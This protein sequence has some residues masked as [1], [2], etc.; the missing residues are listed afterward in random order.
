MVQEKKDSSEKQLE[1][2]ERASTKAD[3]TLSANVTLDL[4]KNAEEVKAYRAQQH[5]SGESGVSVKHK[6]M[7][8]KELLGDLAHS[9]QTKE[10]EQK[11]N[12]ENAY[13]A[14]GYGNPEIPIGKAKEESSDTAEYGTYRIAYESEKQ[15]GTESPLLKVN[16]STTP[17]LVHSGDAVSEGKIERLEDSIEAK[18]LAQLER[19]IQE[20]L[21]C[22]AQRFGEE[23]VANLKIGKGD[24]GMAISALLLGPDFCNAIGND[25]ARKLGKRLIVFGVAPLLGMSQEAQKQFTENAVGTMH[26]GSSNFLVGTAIGALLE[27]CHPAILGTLT[28]GAGGA[29]LNDQLNSTEHQARNEEISHISAQVDQANNTDLLRY[30]ERTK[31]LIGPEIFHGVFALATG[32][33]GLPEGKALRNAGEE[34]LENELTKVDLKKLTE[35]FQELGQNALDSLAETLGAK[36]Q[37]AHVDGVPDVFGKVGKEELD[38]G[39]LMMKGEARS[40]WNAPLDQLDSELRGLS[41]SSL[42]DFCEG[43]KNAQTKLLELNKESVLEK[44]QVNALLKLEDKFQTNYRKLQEEYLVLKRQ[45]SAF[46]EKDPETLTASEESLSEQCYKLEDALYEMTKER[47]EKMYKWEPRATTQRDL[48]V[49]VN[50]G[51]G[52]QRRI[53]NTISS[54]FAENLSKNPTV[55]KIFKERNI[56]MER[57]KDWIGIP[58]QGSPLPAADHGGCDYLLVNKSS[59]EMYCF[60]I[61]ERVSGLNK[62]KIVDSRLTNSTLAINKDTPTERVQW[63]IGTRENTFFNMVTDIKSQLARDPANRKLTESSLYEKAEAMVTEMEKAQVAEIIARAIAVP[64]KL[65][66]YDVRLPS[67]LPNIPVSRKLFE[68]ELFRSDLEKIGF[69]EWAGSLANGRHHLKIEFR[70]NESNRG[71][72]LPFYD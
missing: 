62:G 2:T 32:G 8:A 72:T 54:I 68:L 20:M 60:D 33:A 38:R 15:P 64:S 70:K 11:A 30:S 27:R 35:S 28:I 12:A 43:L 48:S 63:V 17:E 57:A 36:P 52:A 49:S 14:A 37:W 18:K 46:E 53:N 55:A 50:G 41:K 4:R 25:E 5:K 67:N 16:M 56:P 45:V 39:V 3:G 69:T 26:E 44:S 40:S 47:L 22:A 71:L 59:G 51:I 13:Q 65:S 19:G 1:S 58:I 66:L 6:L 42:N 24:V 10:K 9:P 34:Q 29:F 31:T 61:T 23:D 7:P 21:L